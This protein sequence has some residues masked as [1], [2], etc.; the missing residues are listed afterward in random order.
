MKTNLVAVYSNLEN[1]IYFTLKV[2]CGTENRVIH[3][4]SHVKHEA[5]IL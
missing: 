2:T 4:V 1:I 5:I 3:V